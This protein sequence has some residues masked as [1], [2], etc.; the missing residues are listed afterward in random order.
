MASSLDHCSTRLQVLFFY[1]LIASNKNNNQDSGKKK[2]IF[3]NLLNTKY[4]ITTWANTVITEHIKTYVRTS[5]QFVS[6]Y[7]SQLF[8][9]KVETIQI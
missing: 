9:Q 1:K 8:S 5:G 3:E 4:R 6:S 7:Y 2:I